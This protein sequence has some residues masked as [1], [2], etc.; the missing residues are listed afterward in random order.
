[1]KKLHWKQVAS[2]CKQKS[3]ILEGGCA[4]RRWGE[5]GGALGAERGLC[6]VG[7]QSLDPPQGLQRRASGQTEPEKETVHHPAPLRNFISLAKE[8]GPQR[9]RFLWQVC[10]PW[11]YACTPSGVF[12]DSFGVSGAKRTE[13]LCGV[14]IS[15]VGGLNTIVDKRDAWTFSR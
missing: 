10:F 5:G 8:R 6:T 9:K 15:T 11:L 12:S 4:Q 3:R 2:N 7:L 13:T 14:G 1:M